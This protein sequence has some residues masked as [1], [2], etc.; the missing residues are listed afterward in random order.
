MRKTFLKPRYLSLV[1]LI[2]LFLVTC[3]RSDSIPT[4]VPTPRSEVAETAE[5]AETPKAPDTQAS[6]ATPTPAPPSEPAQTPTPRS[7]PAAPSSL[8]LPPVLGPVGDQKVPL[9]ETLSLDLTASDPDGDS[10][11]FAARPLP[12]P[13]Q[14][15][16]DSITGEFA[17]TPALDQVGSFTITF[18]ASDGSAPGIAP[19]PEQ[20]QRI[21]VGIADR[22]RAQRVLAMPTYRRNHP[23]VRA[24][25]ACD[26]TSMIR[27]ARHALDQGGDGAE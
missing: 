27:D 5:P 24:Q 1:A 26:V 19:L 20:S 2:P 15:V 12:L 6:V 10:V 22:L 4:S 13:D 25:D 7:T 18:I 21:A 9:G 16:L 3:T 14:A 17:F 8:N 11:T 23:A